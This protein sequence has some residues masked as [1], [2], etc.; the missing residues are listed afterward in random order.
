MTSTINEKE[1]LARALSEIERRQYIDPT[2]YYEP[3]NHKIEEFHRSTAKTRA[4]FGANRSGKTESAIQ[5]LI[6]YLVGSH[7]FKQVPPPPVYWRVV[8]V[9][10]GQL[11]K[12]VNEKLMRMLPKRLFIDGKWERSYNNRSHILTLTN[13]SKI[14]FMTHEQ[15]LLA[16]EGSARHG[17]LFDEEP[18]Q[19]IYTS[20][21]MRHADY[22]GI[23]LMAMTPLHGLTYTYDDIYLKS[24]SSKNVDAWTISIYENKFLTASA[25]EEIESKITDNVD[26]QI[27][28]YGKFMSRTGLVFKA[29]DPEVHVY[30]A[31]ETE[32][33][34]YYQWWDGR[35]PPHHWLHIIG[36]DPGWDHPTGVI[37]Q[38][39]DYNGDRWIY[40]E[41]KQ[42]GWM[43]EDHADLIKAY[44]EQMGLKE[45]IYVIDSQARAIEQS[46]GSNVWAEYRNND[47]ICRLGTKKLLDGNLKLAEYMKVSTDKAGNKHTHYHVSNECPDF[48][49]EIGKYQRAR[50]TPMNA[51]ERFLD[52]DN[53]LISAARY[54]NWEAEKLF[55]YD[56]D[57][58]S[59][60]Y[61][62]KGSKRT[63]Y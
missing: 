45:V 46:T 18:P 17:T 52:K 26:R 36:I 50:T 42:S 25:I 4:L 54:A 53:D 20:C 49:S 34:S 41:H 19:D 37:W 5:E 29:F 32:D 10:Y 15:P 63:G 44:N 43:P 7:P 30:K 23:T 12:V 57:D 13:G 22:D 3:A 60:E 21:I 62:R 27:R 48:I 58:A 61:E 33:D 9:D 55:A 11:E 1:Y 35:Y 14:D 38:A 51:T 47:I 2:K 59:R 39:V 40:R 8:V 28:L 16:F 56:E 6:W 24:F 31:P